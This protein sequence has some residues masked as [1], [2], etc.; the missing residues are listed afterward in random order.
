MN[1]FSTNT[2]VV[3]RR[4]DDTKNPVEP[5]TLPFVIDNTQIK[6]ASK[7]LAYALPGLIVHVKEKKSGK[8]KGKGMHFPSPNQAM[9]L[10]KT[11]DII[12]TTSAGAKTSSTTIE[13][14]GAI[15]ITL[16]DI[17]QYAQLT[18]VFDQYRLAMVEVTFL[19]RTT[20]NET[21]AAV[22]PM[23]GTAVDVD[24][25]SSPAGFNYIGDYQGSKVTEAY[26]Q[27]KHTF[28]PHIAVAAYSGAFTSY[29]N[30]TAPWID[31][32]STGV[33]HYGVKWAF[34]QTAVQAT[35]DTVVRTWWQFR[36][37][38]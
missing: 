18:S 25:A 26:K 29:E 35:Y 23:F 15:Y 21:Y 28:V 20:Q 10:N 6:E 37:V 12:Q 16:G 8:G 14:T 31:C 33:Q 3:E 17:N 30:V 1:F 4:G 38:R 2:T 13:Q 9:R 5:K 22:T 34:T 7:H 32:A 11:Y 19:P 24:D 27:H 36:S